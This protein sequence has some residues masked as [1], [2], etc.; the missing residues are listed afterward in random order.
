MKKIQINTFKIVVFNDMKMVIHRLE[1]FFFNNPEYKIG[2]AIID[3]KTIIM[4]AIETNNHPNI[5]DI[6][7]IINT[8]GYVTLLMNWEAKL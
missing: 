7:N 1:E 4:N 8:G 2:Y 6:S 3:N 5:S